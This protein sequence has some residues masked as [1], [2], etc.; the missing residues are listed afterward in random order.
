MI[1]KVSLCYVVKY[2]AD[3]NTVRPKYKYQ[4]C[5]TLSIKLSRVFSITYYKKV[6]ETEKG[7]DLNARTLHGEEEKREREEFMCVYLYVCVCRWSGGCAH[8][9]MVKQA[10][11]EVLKLRK[12]TLA[13]WTLP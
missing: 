10:T 8:N 6:V 9:V 11:G 2:V 13:I 3:G 1:R 7:N 5:L 4:H 12:C